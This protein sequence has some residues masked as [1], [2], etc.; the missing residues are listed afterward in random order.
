VTFPELKEPDTRSLTA[1]FVGGDHWEEFHALTAQINKVKLELARRGIIP[2]ASVLTSEGI[3]ANGAAAPNADKQLVQLSEREQKIWRVAQQGSRGLQYCRELE[4]A[5]I[6]PRKKGVWKDC[7]ASYPAAYQ[8]G[9][10]WRHRI[11]DEKYKIRRKAELAKNSPASKSMP[12]PK[13]A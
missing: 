6:K 8:Q 7:P 5:H 9:K 11:Q 10:P 1:Q 12:V 4:A 13:P 3:E 2:G